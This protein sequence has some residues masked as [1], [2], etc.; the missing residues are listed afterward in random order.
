MLVALDDV[1]MMPVYDPLRCLIHTA[2]DRA[3]RDAYVD[4]VKVLSEGRV[5]T[6]DQEEAAAHLTVAQQRI[7]DRVPARDYKGRTAHE[8]SPLTLPIAGALN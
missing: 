4:G 3:V 1:D 8:V 6:L 2:A 5:L 7:M